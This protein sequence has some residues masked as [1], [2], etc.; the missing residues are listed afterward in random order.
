M[1]AAAFAGGGPGGRLYEDYYTIPADLMSTM[2]PAV[3]VSDDTAIVVWQHQ[4]LRIEPRLGLAEQDERQDNC[5][6]DFAV[7]SHYVALAMRSMATN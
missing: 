4:V 1:T 6:K 7:T 2:R 5:F 3:H